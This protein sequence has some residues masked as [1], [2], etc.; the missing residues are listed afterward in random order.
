VR[1]ALETN[2]LLTPQVLSGMGRNLEIGLRRDT[3][4]AALDLSLIEGWDVH[5][6]ARHSS[7]A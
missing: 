1:S 7:I 2:P 5:V 4:A 6:G 3:G